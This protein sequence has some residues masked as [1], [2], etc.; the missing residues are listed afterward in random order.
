MPDTAEQLRPHMPVPTAAVVTS[1]APTGI[2]RAAINLSNFLL[3]TG[4]DSTGGPTGVSPDMAR[5]LAQ[6]L[7][8]EIELIPM[9]SPAAVAD[10]ATE[11]V[12]DIGLIGAE[13]A[14]AVSIAFSTAYC[15]IQSTYMVGPDSTAMTVDDIDQ[16]GMRIASASRAAYDLWLEANLQHAE[17]VH[18]IGL[19]GSF[20]VFVEQN[21][22]ALAGLLP[23]LLTDVK[24]IPGARIIEGQFAA[25][26]Q[27]IGTPRSRSEDGRQFLQSYVEAAIT[28]GLVAD[29]IDKHGATGLSVAVRPSH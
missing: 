3:V 22:D 24:R 15:E 1:L 16:P 12:W 25:V 18:G 26:Q 21:L 10:S 6:L 23:R 17:L 20:D 27:A 13:P 14:R 11:P 4:E 5:T 8:V 9:A 19:G 7:D 29:L 28:S 2:L